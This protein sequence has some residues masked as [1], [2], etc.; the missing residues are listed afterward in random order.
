MTGLAT[1]AIKKQVVEFK[2]SNQEEAVKA[3]D[4]FGQICRHK[5]T[6]I[7]D[8]ICSRYQVDYKTI[9]IDQ[10]ELDLGR[11][12]LEQLEQQLPQLIAS[13]FEE[14]LRKRVHQLTYYGSSPI[15]SD[16]A[17]AQFKT[18]LESNLFI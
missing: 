10:L 9:R 12:Q 2:I 3:Q 8:S 5:I 6:P 18:L 15:Y 13:L 1:H 16:E 17:V 14:E 11:I 7:L 4:R